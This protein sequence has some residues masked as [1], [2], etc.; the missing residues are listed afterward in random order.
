MTDRVEYS[1]NMDPASQQDDS[2]YS[3]S[4]NSRPPSTNYFSLEYVKSNFNQMGS[5]FDQNIE[6]ILNENKQY[7]QKIL[8]LNSQI[9]YAEEV[10]ND[11]AKELEATKLQL[12]DLKSQNQILIQTNENL[13]EEDEQLRKLCSSFKIKLSESAIEIKML[14]DSLKENQS[15]HESSQINFKKIEK[16]KLNEIELYKEEISKLKELYEALEEQNS[17]LNRELIQVNIKF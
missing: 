9:S 5:E 16:E 11:L 3:S 12:N 14:C 10:N 4:L 15:E 2:I 6:E 8:D 1:W 17:K 13:N 7:Q